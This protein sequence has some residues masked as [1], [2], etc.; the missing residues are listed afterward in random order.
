[1]KTLICL[2]LS[3]LILSSCATQKRC[4][5]K[6]PP[7][8]ETNTEYIETIKIDT[9]TLPGDSLIIET[10]VPCDDFDII[11]ENT[12][13]RSEISVLNGKLVSRVTL[14]RD[15]VYLP[16]K[17]VFKKE[18][19]KQIV[20]VKECP[21]WKTKLAWIG[22]GLIVLIILYIIAKIKKFVWF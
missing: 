22:I 4:T 5:K 14:K 8:T 20:T 13:L 7:V 11:T 21:K 18:Y 1:M 15:T 6:F 2:I 10:K 9:I 3:S 17:T 12:S 16:S 19:I